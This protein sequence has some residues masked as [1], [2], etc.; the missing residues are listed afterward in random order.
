MGIESHGEEEIYEKN[1]L[2]AFA[3][4]LIYIKNFFISSIFY[5]T[6]TEIN[7]ILHIEQGQN[8]G[9]LTKKQKELK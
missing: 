4:F 1:S 8:L 7:D 2:F 3:A 5:L 9:K 6:L